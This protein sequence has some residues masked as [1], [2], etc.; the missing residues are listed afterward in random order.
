[1][2]VRPSAPMI[3]LIEVTGLVSYLSV[4]PPLGD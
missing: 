3:R 2:V 1:V 4:E